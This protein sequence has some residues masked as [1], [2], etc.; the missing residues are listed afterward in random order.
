M[1]FLTTGIVGLLLLGVGKM[2]VDE[3]SA[4]IP[5][6]TVMQQNEHTDETPGISTKS[7]HSNQW[8]TPLY[9]ETPTFPLYAFPL[10]YVVH[11][12]GISISNP[13]VTTGGDTVFAPFREDV[14]ITFPS[15]KKPVISSIGDWTI[16]MSHGDTMTTIGHGLPYAIIQSP[17]EEV[18]ISSTSTIEYKEK[19]DNFKV[20]A[21][22][23]STYISVF[24][25]NYTLIGL[26]PEGYT[27]ETI[28]LFRS[29]NGMTIQSSVVSFDEKQ[30]QQGTFSATYKLYTTGDSPALIALYPHHQKSLSGTFSSLGTYK[31]LRGTLSL[32]QANEFTTTTKLIVPE[33]TFLPLQQAP[34]LFTT[35]LEED[36]ETFIQSTPPDG[37]YFKG[38]WLAKGSS[39][40]QLAD[41]HGL[42]N[43]AT[44]LAR[45]LEREFEKGLQTISYNQ[46]KTSMVAQNTEFGND[47][48]N[49]HHFHYGYYIRTAA[50]L[51][52][53]KKGELSEPVQ[54][55]VNELV[56][57]IAEHD[58]SSTLFPYA[59]PFDWYEGHSWADGDGATPDG[60]NQESTSEAINAWYAVWLWGD[61][62]NNQQAGNMGLVLYNR[63]I[64][65]AK[66]Y[67]F[68]TGNIYPS[69]YPHAIVS[70]LWGGKAD[71]LTWF[72]PDANMKYG[73]QLM[74]F[75]PGSSYLGSFSPND[76]ERFRSHWEKTGGSFDKPWG[77]MFRMWFSM[78]DNQSLSLEEY[79]KDYAD[80]AG[81][82]PFSLFAYFLLKNTR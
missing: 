74:P 80:N 26:L 44:S 58:R 3:Q 11:D 33:R 71:Y 53:F 5:T 45:T 66:I 65:S 42:G 1:K 62:T 67:W 40:L 7:F 23:K 57:D 59:R 32:M 13:Q 2:I 12:D 21:V 41:V 20:M 69:D 79:K 35:S 81:D 16:T 38:K 17:N 73:I 49:D 14:R 24:E 27:P 68:N 70:L 19:G 10:A 6:P 4:P 37:V 61:V 78:Y 39:L 25:K 54:K 9:G 64:E 55:K 63:E 75:T 76:M 8:Y 34:Q 82:T 72:S 51:T 48:L 50:V 18:S 77:N 46:Q 22:N 52:M 31:T 30:R 43:A 47:E 15:T 36:I 28:D 60:N 56:S 29:M